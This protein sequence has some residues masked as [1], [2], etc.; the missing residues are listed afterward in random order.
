MRDGLS[1]RVRMC[2]REKP[3]DRI[4]LRKRENG[5]R[6]KESER[7]GTRFET[8]RKNGRSIKKNA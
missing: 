3:C 5:R 4:R 7:A 1:D 2:I 8:P 6:T